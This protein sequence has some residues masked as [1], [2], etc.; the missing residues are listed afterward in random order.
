M[1]EYKQRQAKANEER[2]FIALKE[3]NKPVSAVAV[4]D[5]LD[6]K[7]KEEAAS[8]AKRKHNN[9]ELT[10]DSIEEYVIKKSRSIDLRTVQRW[11]STLVRKGFVIRDNNRYYLSDIGKLELQF[12]YFAQRYGHMALNSLMDCYFPTINTLEENLTKLIEIFGIYVV[13]CLI[14]A[15]RLITAAKNNKEEHWHSSYFGAPINF[16]KE[17]KFREEKLV[18]SWVKDVFNPWQMLNLFLTCVSNVS[19]NEERLVKSIG[20]DKDKTALNEYHKHYGEYDL[21]NTIFFDSVVHNKDK[22]KNTQS[23]LSFLPSPTALDLMFKRASSIVA[24]YG[25]NDFDNEKYLQS[26]MTDKRQYHYIKNITQY[27][28]DKLLYELD[29]DKIKLL[30]ETLKK[31]YS[32]YYKY[33]Q[34]TDRFFYSNEPA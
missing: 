26:L 31:N 8:E 30:K 25:P 14:E 18:I 15:A 29:D 11:L 17:G 28:E 5:H 33:L 34:K 3:L 12:R 22:E 16:D 32:S 23:V 27:N 13:Y 4:K 20:Y 21:P 10:S 9:G 2:V 7:A 24:S 6:N 1:K 19:R